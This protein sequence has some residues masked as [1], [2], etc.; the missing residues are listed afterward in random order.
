MAVGGLLVGALAAPG[1]AAG[2]SV[3]W[4]ASATHKVRPGDPVGT[5]TA[6]S[7]AAAR[8]EFEAFQVVVV[9]PANGVSVSA[10]DLQGPRTIGGVVLYREALI[11]LANASASDGA[12]GRFPDALVPDVD[13]VVGEKRNAFPFDVPAGESRAVWVEVLV[14]PDAPAGTYQGS[15]TVH[16]AQGEVVVPVSLTVWDFALPSTA[17]LKSTFGLSYGTLPAG[18][19]V[20]GDEFSRLRA[21]YSQLGLDHRISLSKFD[22]GNVDIGHFDTWFGPLM[23]GTASTRLPGARLTTLQYMGGPGALAAWVQHCKAKG[24]FERLFDYTCDEPPATC[25]WSDIPARRAVVKAADPSFRTLVTTMIDEA[26]AQGVASSIDIMVPVINFLRAPADADPY[27]PFLAGSPL[28]ELWLYQSCMSHGCGG[29]AEGWPSTMI[30]AS[31]VRSRAMEWMSFQRGAT[32]ELYWETTFAYS[33]DAWAN[34]WDFTGNGDGTLFY[35]GTPARIG[36]ATHIPVASIRLKMIREGM[37]DYEYLKRVADLGDPGL[38][39]QLAAALFP[40]AQAADVSV[41][42]LMAARAQLAARIVELSGGTVVPPGDGGVPSGDGGLT[43]GAGDAGVAASDGS[44][45]VGPSGPDG[46]TTGRPDSQGGAGAASLMGGCQ[47]AGTSSAM[48]LLFLVGL[49]PWS[50][51][52]AR[53]VGR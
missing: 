48:S 1:P 24:W 37:E 28:R 36:G 11:D 33:H 44:V 32:G 3:T 7:L 4:V 26:D 6:A 46:A 23:D 42:A 10:S 16:S 31:A 39:T 21:R 45:P 53:R 8:N 35:P 2:A 5:S 30:D 41:D 25:S 43:P 50:A 29:S 52:R 13:D 51:G 34:Q 27:A 49:L 38:A 12:T 22:D 20:S 15:V 9:G 47:A 18:H 17:S 14:P 40:N 19:G